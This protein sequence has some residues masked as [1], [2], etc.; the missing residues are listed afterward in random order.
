[1]SA[2]YFDT[3]ALVKRYFPETGSAW[4][5]A[6][7]DPKAEHTLLISAMTRVEA[8]AAFAIK[9]RSGNA[10]RQDRD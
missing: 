3:S 9:H 4:V 2:Y 5:I 8:A 7:T 1:M 10:T 6:V